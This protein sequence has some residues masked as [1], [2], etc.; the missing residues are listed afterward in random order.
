MPENQT[1]KKRV[2]KKKKEIEW[3]KT[4]ERNSERERD[5]LK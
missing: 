1:K 2:R 3:E 5:E 4:M